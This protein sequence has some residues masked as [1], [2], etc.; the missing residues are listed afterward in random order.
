MNLKII[1]LSEG[2]QRKKGMYY[3][4]ILFVENSGKCKLNFSDRKQIST[5]LGTGA[6]RE[7]QITKGCTET[8]E[9]NRCSLT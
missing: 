2:S 1:M 4:M 5:Y 3:C 8:F 7:G 9:S 6:G